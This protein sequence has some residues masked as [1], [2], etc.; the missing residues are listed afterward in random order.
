MFIICYLIF[1][2]IRGVIFKCL[3]LLTNQTQRYLVESDIKQR[4]A[5]DLI[6]KAAT[7]R[8]WLFLLIQKKRLKRI[9]EV[10]SFQFSVNQLTEKRCSS[11]IYDIHKD[12]VSIQCTLISTISAHSTICLKR[13]S[14]DCQD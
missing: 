14:S 5:N 6:G 9:I 1:R 12:T 10:T 13:S 3:V 2:R 4:N 7:S 8:F 11:N